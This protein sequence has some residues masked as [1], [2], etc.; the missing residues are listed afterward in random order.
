MHI[1]ITILTILASFKWAD[2]KNWRDY[3]ASM[4]FISTGGMM[5]EYIV[6][7]NTLWK[8]HPDFLYGHEMVVLVYA[9]ITM[10]ISILLFLSHFP[11]TWMKRLLYII[12]WSGIYISVEWILL[13]FGRISYQNGW[14][15]WYSFYF[16]IMMFSIIALHQHKPFRA[17]IISLPVI[18]FLIFYFDI[19]FKFGK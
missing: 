6:Q 15:F 7:E 10:P 17:Y 4:Y 5:Y 18:L 12:V 2:W 16:D 13:V 3:H 9:I 1:A 14:K 19:P 11:E 8:F